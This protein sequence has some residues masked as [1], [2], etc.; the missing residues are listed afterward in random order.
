MPMIS[1]AIYQR[2]PKK[3]A[4]II[5]TQIIAIIVMVMC[6]LSV[7]D[8]ILRHFVPIEPLVEVNRGYV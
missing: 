7:F 2:P 8:V 4:A 3:R 6:V 5:R 1:A